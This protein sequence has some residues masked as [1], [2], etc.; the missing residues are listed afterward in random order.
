MLQAYA[1]LAHNS[2]TVPE[3][4]QAVGD[5]V[6]LGAAA[7]QEAAVAVAGAPA[8][9][10]A[11]AAA[12]AAAAPAAAAQPPVAASSPPAT[13]GPP[14]P[15]S[16][17]LAHISSL[18]ESHLRLGYRPPAF[19]LQC[20]APQ[21]CRLLPACPAEDAARLLCLLAAGSCSPG[22]A[23]VGRLLARAVDGARSAEGGDGGGAMAAAAR[24][25]ADDLLALD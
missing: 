22:S 14:A 19:L 2:V 4:L 7:Q 16:F 24:R 3:L 15:D 1:D 11:A 13:H 12:P 6:R 5:Q 18:V 9:A 25:A 20:L 8:P 21:I 10:G 17:T 23:V